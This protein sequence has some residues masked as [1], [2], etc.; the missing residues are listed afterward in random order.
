MG[1]VTTLVHYHQVCRFAEV[2]V[3]FSSNR[4]NVTDNLNVRMCLE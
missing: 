2:P 3:A 4:V 1:E